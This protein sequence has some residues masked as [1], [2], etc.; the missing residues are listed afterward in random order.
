MRSYE[1]DNKAKYWHL[2]MLAM[3]IL[4]LHCENADLKEVSLLTKNCHRKAT[5][6]MKAL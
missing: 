2:G 6:K 3:W 1:T 4:L 5:A